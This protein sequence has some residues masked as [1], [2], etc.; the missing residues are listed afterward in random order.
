[1]E[2]K[3]ETEEQRAR[4]KEGERAGRAELERWRGRDMGHRGKRVGGLRGRGGECGSSGAEG[5]LPASRTEGPGWSLGVGQRS[6]VEARGCLAGVGD[7]AP[8]PLPT[9][10][11]NPP[12]ARKPVLSLLPPSRAPSLPPSGRA[13][14]A[15]QP[16]PK[17]SSPLF[18][19]GNERRGSECSPQ[20]R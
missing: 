8:A 13:S 10:P 6:P 2:R 5:G 20:T 4:D 7:H 1:M 9:S 19:A 14:A 16:N 11:A 3:G 18:R 17:P 12:A 15:S